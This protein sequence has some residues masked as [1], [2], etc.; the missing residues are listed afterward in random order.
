MSLTRKLTARTHLAAF[1]NGHLPKKDL[2]EPIV[3]YPKIDCPYP[4]TQILAAFPKGHLPKKRLPEPPNVARK[5]AA[6]TQ[7]TRILAALDSRNFPVHY[8]SHSSPKMK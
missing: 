6:R 2:P 1:P 3:T 4:L 7:S 5:L 8:Q